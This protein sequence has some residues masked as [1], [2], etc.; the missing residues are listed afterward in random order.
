MISS[1]GFKIDLEGKDI[2]QLFILKTQPTNS[3]YGPLSPIVKHLSLAINSFI[4]QMKLDR[5]QDT[6]STSLPIKKT[7]IYISDFWSYVKAFRAGFKHRSQRN[8]NFAGQ[9]LWTNYLW[10][11]EWLS[12]SV[13]ELQTGK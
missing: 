9:L 12:V 13:S 1:D 5:S 2:P 7:M 4:D 11:N 10:V 6:Q 8:W 3:H